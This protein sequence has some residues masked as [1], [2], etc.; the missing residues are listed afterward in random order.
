MDILENKNLYINA[1]TF[2]RV[3]ELGSYSAAARKTSL[4]Q[5]TISRRIVALENELSLQL[6]RRNT[7]NLEITEEGH[8][9]YNFFIEHETRFSTSIE[10]FKT[11]RKEG[12]ICL[13]I[14]IP[15][16]IANYVL[17]PRI[18]EYVHRHPNLTLQIFYQNREVDL[19]KETFDLV[20]LRHIPKH[21]TLKIKKLYKS[22]LNLYCTPEYI[23]RFGEPKTI[24]ELKNHTLTGAIADDSSINI[25][26]ELIYKD[27]DKIN[28]RYLPRILLNSIDSALKIAKS[29]YAMVGGNDYIYQDEL[30][31]G[32]LVKVLSDYKIST[33]EFYMVRLSNSKNPIIDDLMQFIEECFREIQDF[34]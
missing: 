22:Y 10:R 18:A 27:K 28:F 26:T 20:I 25:N 1:Q 21:Q 31:R 8:N 2:C 19:I 15:M 12:D 11:D 29:G 16:G 34:G 24:E 17:S 32:E 23:K 4:S 14:A 3:V 30:A 7:R 5:S 9:F 13:R 6:I 33:W